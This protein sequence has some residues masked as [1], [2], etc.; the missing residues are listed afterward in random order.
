MFSDRT[1]ADRSVMTY[2]LMRAGTSAEA[3]RIDA[4]SDF[5]AIEL[6][7]DW[8]VRAGDHEAD[9]L[10]ARGDGS[11][12]AHFVRTVAGQ[13]YAIGQSAGGRLE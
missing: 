1:L 11:H 3:T 7:R 5:A 12:L 8:L 13:W 2:F 9:Y 10:L 4:A 6:S